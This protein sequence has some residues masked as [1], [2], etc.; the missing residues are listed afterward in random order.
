MFAQVI[1][2]IAD[3]SVAKRIRR[4]VDG[5]D[6]HVAALR[7]GAAAWSQLLRQGA[8]LIILGRGVIPTPATESIRG[9]RNTPD[10]PR[11]V[12]LRSEPAPIDDAELSAAGCSAVIDEAVPP[13]TLK[14]VFD[15]LIERRRQEFSSELAK[16]APTLRSHISDIQSQSPRMREFVEFVKKIVATDSTLLITGETGVGK[17]HL[18]RAIHGDSPRAA[19]PFVSVNCGALPETLL[20]SEL[21]GHEE[22]AFT[23][24]T[25]SRRG[26]F[27]LAHG[28]T[29]FLDEIGDLARHLQVKLLHVLQTKEV[30]RVGGGSSIPVNARIMAA[31]NKDLDEELA[32]KRFRLDLYY[33]LSVITLEIPPLRDRPEDIPGLVDR[34]IR[35]LTTRFQAQACD[36]SPD[37]LACLCRYHWPGNIRELINIL[38]RTLLLT[39]SERIEVLDLPLSVR[40]LTVDALAVDALAEEA[41]APNNDGVAATRPPA[42]ITDQP[43]REA[44]RAAVSAIELQYL[45]AVLTQTR[46]RVG[47]A[48]EIAGMQRRSLYSKLKLHDLRKEDFRTREVE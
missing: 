45:R 32:A 30:Q 33:R 36:I 3:E 18:A 44:C 2:F 19:G 11:V 6:R 35:H 25:R 4:L 14:D 1:V 40:G 39:E 7:P 13:N 48:A 37:A 31:T 21:F 28:G 5:P 22:G 29:I 42:N 26:W 15:H 9:L 27:E 8:D 23:G 24:A 41:L 12:I 46:G 38:E 17:E 43:L 20:E 47:R 34:F 10:A 16:R